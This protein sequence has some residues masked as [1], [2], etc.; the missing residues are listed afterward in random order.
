MHT[1][2]LIIALAAPGDMVYVVG[3]QA[4]TLSIPDKLE[5][6]SAIASSMEGKLEMSELDRYYCAATTVVVKNRRQIN[7]AAVKASLQWVCTGTDN[8]PNKTDD[9]AADLELD[10]LV[11]AP[12]GRVK[13]HL[14]ENKTQSEFECRKQKMS[15]DAKV[16]HESFLQAVF[17]KPLVVLAELECLRDPAIVGKFECGMGRIKIAPPAVWRVD[18]KFGRV[19]RTIGKVAP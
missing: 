11:P 9:E 8:N 13:C 17:E 6:D 18:K 12:E 5:L 3:Q 10:S 19:A 16:L 2:L 1:L 15:I 7:V 14:R 4:V